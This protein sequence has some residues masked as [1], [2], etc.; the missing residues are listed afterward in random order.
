M[1]Y[2]AKRTLCA[3]LALVF[4]C[5]LAA[6]GGAKAGDPERKSVV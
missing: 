6:C 3:L 2:T 4:V 1:K 5:G